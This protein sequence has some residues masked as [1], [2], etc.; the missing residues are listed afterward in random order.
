MY[1]PAARGFALWN[2]CASQLSGD[3]QVDLRSERMYVFPNPLDGEGSNPHPK[4]D[5]RK[6]L[7]MSR[8][9]A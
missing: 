8:P 9:M 7:E 4:A 6:K 1:V 3:G 2:L 5:W